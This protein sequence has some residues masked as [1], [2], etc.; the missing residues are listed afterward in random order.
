MFKRGVAGSLPPS[1]A[2]RVLPE[3]QLSARP[4]ARSPSSIAFAWRSRGLD[5]R[6]LLPTSSR[7]GSKQCGSGAIESSIRR[8]IN[9]RMKNNGMLLMAS[10]RGLV[11]L[12]RRWLPAGRPSHSDESSRLC[13]SVR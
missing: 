10:C 5:V 13:G 1:K 12:E 4:R 2:R 11:A 7:Y 9:L 6:D 8:V 3:F